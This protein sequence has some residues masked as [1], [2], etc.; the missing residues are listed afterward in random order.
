MFVPKQ[1]S[2][3]VE[4]QDIV[5]VHNQDVILVQTSVG[6][7]MQA[8]VSGVLG[9]PRYRWGTAHMGSAEVCITHVIF[10]WDPHVKAHVFVMGSP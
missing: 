1:Y 6:G 4:E 2:V 10:H 5:L 3:L 8:S 7:V 9:S